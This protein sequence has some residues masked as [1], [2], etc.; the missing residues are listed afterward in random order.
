MRKK[1]AGESYEEK[2]RKVGLLIGL[3]KAAPKLGKRRD[4]A[5]PVTGTA[6]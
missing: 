1:L 4:F 5:R 6:R 2:I 3:V